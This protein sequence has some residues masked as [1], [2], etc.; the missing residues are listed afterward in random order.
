M[1]HTQPLFLLDDYR[2]IWKLCSDPIH[3]Y[4][5]QGP[6]YFWPIYYIK[7]KVWMVLETVRETSLLYSVSFSSKIPT[8]QFNSENNLMKWRPCCRW[9]YRG[10]E[11]NSILRLIQV[12]SSRTRRLASVLWKTK[13]SG[14]HSQFLSFIFPDHLPNYLSKLYFYKLETFFT[15]TTHQ[16]KMHQI[17]LIFLSIYY[18]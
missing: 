1:R 3:L 10:S 6:F 8:V 2:R 13:L 18:L 14:L 5:S 15:Y 9:V 17:M 16:N 4:I 11:V 12:E 7:G